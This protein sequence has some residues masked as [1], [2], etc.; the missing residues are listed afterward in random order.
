MLICEPHGR[1]AV[2][3]L[4]DDTSIVNAWFSFA[5]NAC[6]FP[7]PHKLLEDLPAFPNSFRDFVSRPTL[8][9]NDSTQVN[10][11][12]GLIML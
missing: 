7:N 9:V 2:G 11:R 6:V 4:A 12:D 3:Q 5:R 10:H 1:H 8:R